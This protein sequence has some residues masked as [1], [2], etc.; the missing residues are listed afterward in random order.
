MVFGETNILSIGHQKKSL[1]FLFNVSTEDQLTCATYETL[2]FTWCIV[3]LQTTQ[4]NDNDNF[5]QV[6]CALPTLPFYPFFVAAILYLLFRSLII[7]DLI[8][9]FSSVHSEKK[10]TQDRASSV[11]ILTESNIPEI[12]FSTF[13]ILVVL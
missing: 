3:V 8:I 2:Q 9:I 10:I 5:I 6:Q 13:L 1:A 11:I 12:L 7:Y 4:T